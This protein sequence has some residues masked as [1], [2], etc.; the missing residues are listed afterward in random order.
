MA[1][2]AQIATAIHGAKLYHERARRAL[3]LLVR[4][5]EAGEPIF[6]SDLASELG[7][8]NPRVLNFPLGAIGTTL[9][10]LS[11]A[12]GEKIPP[13]QCLVVNRNTGLPGEGVGW[14]IVKKEDY[15]RLPLSRRREIVRAELARVRAYPRWRDVLA[16]VQLPPPPPPV[17]P[18]LLAQAA[19]RGGGEGEEHRALKEWVVRHPEL[20]GLG[21]ATRGVTERPLPS[22]DCM[23]VSFEAAEEWVGVEVK[24]RI[25]GE[26]DILRGLF[27]CV[28]Y[29]AVM[30]AVQVADG[31]TRA[32]RAVLVLEGVLP[33]NLHAVRNALAIEVVEGAVAKDRRGPSS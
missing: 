13:I 25:S 15:G 7:I 17:S 30:E 2:T 28:K 24:S 16:N 31:R 33:P 1:Q 27:Q 23:D 22:G 18:A 4:Q 29:R 26:A 5:A 19:G 3:P 9:E 21:R 12:W 11:E 8:S 32:A 14:F 20:F 6:Y 10:Q